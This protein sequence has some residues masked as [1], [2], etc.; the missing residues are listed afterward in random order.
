MRRVLPGLI[1]T[2][3]T[4]GFAAPL[5]GQEAGAGAAASSPRISLDGRWDLLVD[6]ENAGAAKGVMSG[7][8]PAWDKV[9]K[10][11]VP[12]PFETQPQAAGFDG[13]VWYRLILP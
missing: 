7:S 6:R 10:V 4:I 13:I 12:G 11:A 8:G 5:R 9:F 3:L 2:T 1:L